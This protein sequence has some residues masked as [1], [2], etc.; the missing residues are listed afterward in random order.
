LRGGKQAFDVS[1][2]ADNP[3]QSPTRRRTQRERSEE[4]AKRLLDAA[5]ELIAEKGFERT[6][7]AEIGERA[8]YSRSMV[9][10]RYGS[11]EALLESIFGVELDRRLMPVGDRDLTGLP[12]V[13]TRIDH[14]A[15]L[16]DEERE[17]MRAFCV[18]SMEAGVAISSLR[19]WYTTWLGAYE[20]QMAVHLREGQRDG[21]VRPDLD[22]ETE[23]AHF[24]LTGL[25]LIFR[26]SLSPDS[27]DLAT[28]FR[29]WRTRLAAVYA[30]VAP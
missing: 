1:T 3:R 21:T 17:L 7:V 28:Q 25:G 10:A 2:T 14:V 16:L 12:W 30:P 20:A 5:I 13:L 8:G 4:S 29:L 22:P 11:K 18:M 19:N 24:V 15:R 9:R 27:Y 23:A 26:W 6:T